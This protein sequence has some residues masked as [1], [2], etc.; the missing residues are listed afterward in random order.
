[1]IPLNTLA[2]WTPSPAELVVI[3]IVALLLFGRRLPEV[4]RNLG[5]GVVEFKKGLKGV[6]DDVEQGGS[7][8]EGSYSSP[9]SAPKQVSQ[10]TASGASSSS[11]PESGTEAQTPS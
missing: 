11:A 8:S 3:M 9:D 10:P 7:S 1:M 4:A 2:F 6:E 5:K